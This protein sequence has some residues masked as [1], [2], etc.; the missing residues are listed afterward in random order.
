MLKKPE[1]RR[2]KK[3]LFLTRQSSGLSDMPELSIVIV[4]LNNKDLILDCIDSIQ[5]EG[6]GL[7]LEII[8][9][10]N[11]ST[12]GS[13]G[14]LRR[15]QDSN[16]KIQ[17]IENKG[18]LGYAKANNQGIEKTGGKYILLLNSDTIV[19]KGALGKLMKFAQ[20][21]LDAGVVGPKLL[22]IDGSLQPSCFNFPTIRNAIKE[23]WLGD[24]GLFEK[25][26]PTGE[27]PA[28]VDAVVGAAFL[29]SPKA[30]KKVGMLDERYFAYF[31]D[32]DY[33][34]QTWKKGLKVYYLP[35]S[36][37]I[38]YH[39]AT[40]KKMSPEKDRWKRLI[41]GSKIYHGIAKHYI[42]T[43][44]IWLGQKWVQLT[45]GKSEQI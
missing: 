1:K 36:E 43:A 41:P 13:V 23:Y 4:N 11:G 24:K 3:Q 34:R 20:K 45:K 28:E 44:I 42:L 17:I 6:S 35:T 7:E 10:D 18:N 38:H 25:F 30:L 2:K 16:I 40:F 8:I 5:K 14:A 27:K 31:E 12:D 22:N 39:G 33:C 15:I 19:K 26:A 29:I 32:I 9:T 37:I 21:N